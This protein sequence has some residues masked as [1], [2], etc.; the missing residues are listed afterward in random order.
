MSIEV[1]QLRATG[2]TQG[3]PVVV[4]SGGGVSTAE[5]VNADAINAALPRWKKV[6]KTF[7]DL[8]AAGLTNDIEVYS[9]LAGEVI[10]AVKTKHSTAFSGGTIASYTVSVGIVGNLVKYSAAFD[11][12]QATSNTAFQLSTTVGSENH[13]AAPSIRLAAVSTVD[14][15][16]QA[17]A[18]SVDVWLLVSGAT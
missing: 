18:G 8:S 4:G 14:N 13:G 10:H 9:L 16:D 6:T 17:A 1:K 2:A 12:F 7:T 5:T 15:L 3:R 11:V